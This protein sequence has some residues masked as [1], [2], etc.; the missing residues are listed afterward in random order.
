MVMYL[1][2]GGKQRRK[3]TAKGAKNMKTEKEIIRLTKIHQD[4]DKGELIQ[5]INH[6]LK[7][8]G[9]SPRE[10]VQWVC[11]VTGS[12]IGTAYTWFTNAKCRRE[13]KIPLYVLC[14]IALVLK[15]PVDAFFEIESIHSENRKEKIDRRGKLYWHLRH[16]VAENLWDQTHQPEE[17]WKVQTKETR[18]T[19]LDKLYLEEVD[20]KKQE[21]DRRN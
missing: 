11:K 8:H 18:K 4:A 6:V 21:S 13:N 9:I 16:K 10:K 20:K 7:T 15:M 14:K 12:P 17:N 5:R 2:I 19:F 1:E 3:S